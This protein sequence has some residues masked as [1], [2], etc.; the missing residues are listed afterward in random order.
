VQGHYGLDDNDFRLGNPVGEDFSSTL[1]G[2]F[3]LTVSSLKKR[4]K[5]DHGTQPALN[6]CLYALEVLCCCERKSLRG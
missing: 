1:L 4:A 2:S 5:R 3:D 6:G